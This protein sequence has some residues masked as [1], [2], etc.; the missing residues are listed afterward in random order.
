ML[1]DVTI[2]PRVP[3]KPLQNDNMA[4]AHDLKRRACDI[5]CDSH[6][7]EDEIRVMVS[8]YMAPKNDEDSKLAIGR[9]VC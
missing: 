7:I 1:P 4:K 6:G 2:L 8:S 5:A 3:Q 9:L